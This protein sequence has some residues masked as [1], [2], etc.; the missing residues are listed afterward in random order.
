[1][2]LRKACNHPYLFYGVEEPNLP[3]LGAHLWKVSGKMRIL[4]QL[5]NKLKHN[6]QVLIFS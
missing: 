4:D 2:N 5:L 1:M 3:T 6:H